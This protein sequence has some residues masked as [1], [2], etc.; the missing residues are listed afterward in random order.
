MHILIASNDAPYV[1]ATAQALGRLGHTV[2]RRTVAD[3]AF[4][5]GRGP[6]DL[7][8]ADV[9]GLAVGV[10]ALLEALR[11]C[12]PLAQTIVIGRRFAIHERIVAYEFG[13]DAFIAKSSGAETLLRAV[14]VA[15]SAWHKN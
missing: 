12:E 15:S 2:D 5:P 11:E 6:H 14:Q 7:V 4:G 9:A 13:V 8:V 1:E 3:A 10:R